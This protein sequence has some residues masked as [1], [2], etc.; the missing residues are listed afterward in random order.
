MDDVLATSIAYYTRHAQAAAAASCASRPSSRANSTRNREDAAFAP[1]HAF[2]KGAASFLEQV[3]A[4]EQRLQAQLDAALQVALEAQGPVLKQRAEALFAVV[5]R[6]KEAVA[7]VPSGEPLPRELL[8]TLN[9]GILEC[10]KQT[11]AKPSDAIP[12]NL[13]QAAPDSKLY[14]SLRKKVEALCA[15]PLDWLEQREQQRYRDAVA[16]GGQHE[17]YDTRAAEVNATRSHRIAE[18]HTKFAEDLSTSDHLPIQERV[19]MNNKGETILVSSWNTLEFPKAGATEPVLDGVKPVCDCL[20]KCIGQKSKERIHWLQDAMSSK[21]VIERHT[22]R[23]LNFVQESIQ[24]HHSQV[25]L[26]QEIGFDVQ[27]KLTE[28]CSQRGWSSHFSRKCD[29]DKKC[30]AITAVISPDSFDEVDEFECQRYSKK[31][32]FA[33]VRQKSLWTVSC[34]LPLVASP[35][36]PEDFDGSFEPK[37]LAQLWDHFGSRGPSD[38]VRC[39]LLA[40]GDWN[41]ELWAAVLKARAQPP[42]GSSSVTLH[43]PDSVTSLDDFSRDLSA[44]PID[45]VL[46]VQ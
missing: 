15:R 23:I 17:G 37:V 18:L 4:L 31:R 44:G 6:A 14:P 26:L 10:E 7:S 46:C 21:V 42:T 33:A 40:G 45:G 38:A 36:N 28:L 41:T 2:V 20:N 24:V 8:S 9:R 1:F 13:L 16:K 22:Q 32:R 12:E 3:D 19:L 27:D 5:D 30:N 43:A 34:H 25:V 29:D 39:T 11:G 35:K